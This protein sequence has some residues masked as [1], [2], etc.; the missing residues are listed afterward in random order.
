MTSRNIIHTRDVGFYFVSK[1]HSAS[2]ARYGVLSRYLLPGLCQREGEHIYK[3]QRQAGID[4]ISIFDPWIFLRRHWIN[5][6]L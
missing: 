4:L 3:A 5:R 2:V 6:A 1:I